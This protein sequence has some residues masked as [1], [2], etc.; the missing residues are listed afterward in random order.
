MTL[1]GLK[2]ALSGRTRRYE[3]AKPWKSGGD[4][5]IESQPRV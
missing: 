1:D 3:L 2:A 4:L 5:A